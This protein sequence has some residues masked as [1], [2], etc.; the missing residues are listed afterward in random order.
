MELASITTT[1]NWKAN[2]ASIFQ[3]ILSSIA[4]FT[5]SITKFIFNVCYKVLRCKKALLYSYKCGLRSS[6][7]RLIV[8]LIIRKCT[9][10]ILKGSVQFTEEIGTQFRNE[11]VPILFLFDVYVRPNQSGT[12]NR[13][14]RWNNRSS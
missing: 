9:A 13:Y 2:S 3:R 12:S 1:V 10:V 7:N 11:L 8:F 6:N 4:A 5:F 14:R